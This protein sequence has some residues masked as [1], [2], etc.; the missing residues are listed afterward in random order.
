MKDDQRRVVRIVVRGKAADGDRP[1]VADLIGQVQDF[2]KLLQ[3]LEHSLHPDGDEPEIV[4]RVARAEMNSPLTMDFVGEAKRH[5]YSV[6][7]RVIQTKSV[8]IGGVRELSEHSERPPYFTDEALAT[9]GRIFH[10]V[11]N[12][13]SQTDIVDPKT[14]QA[15][16]IRSEVAAR[17]ER[18]V[19]GLLFGAAGSWPTDRK[20]AK[21]REAGS[22]EGMLVKV[23]RWYG[24]PAFWVRDRLTGL[25]ILCLASEALAAQW[26]EEARLR[27]VWSGKRLV[28]LGMIE[29][30]PSGQIRLLRADDVY[31]LPQADRLP[32]LEEILDPDFTGG[33]PPVAYLE[34]LR[35]AEEA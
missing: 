15:A 33:I 2:L 12:G 32:K 6:D 5:G 28:V 4:W 27:E 11:T 14:D 30:Q 7:E 3:E 25:D 29:H 9:T 26:G 10:R 34:T 24:H 19:G 21:G 17:A 1:T 13:L 18:H 35:G 8:L 22:I 23:D 20:P 31:E 16:P